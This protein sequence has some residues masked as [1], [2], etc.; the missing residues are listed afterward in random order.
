MGCIDDDVGLEGSNGLQ[1]DR[2]LSFQSD[3]HTVS[4]GVSK[5]FGT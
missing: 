5:G 2:P 1:K 4:V 3:F